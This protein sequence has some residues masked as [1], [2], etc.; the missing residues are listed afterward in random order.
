MPLLWVADPCYVGVRNVETAVAW[1]TEK[2]GLVKTRV[3]PDEAEG[4]IG[5]TF[6][7]EIP[8]P[9]VLCPMAPAVGRATP[10]F[11]TD[12][13]EMAR[14]LLNSR[15]VGV[16]TIETDRQGTRYFEMHDLE[17]N[18]LEVSEEP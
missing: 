5:L 14:A 6:P 12:N 15:K 10:T 7:K 17:G 9:I 4:C 18:V 13:I 11:Y 3:G 8:A 1:Y 16:G 2:L